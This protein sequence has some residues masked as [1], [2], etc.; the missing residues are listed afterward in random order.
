V[1]HAQAV[2][3][4]PVALEEIIVTA[5]RREESLQQTAIAVTA[6]SEDALEDV[7]AQ[8]LADL[9]RLAP[10]AQFGGGA[11]GNSLYIRGIGQQQ[12][13]ILSDPGSALYV[14]GVYRPHVVANSVNFGGV[15]RI[16]VLRGPQG[17]LFGKN[18]VGGSVNIITAT[19][20]DALNG[21]VGVEFGSRNRQRHSGSISMPLVQDQL[22]AT[23]AVERN[24][25]DG[26]VRNLQTGESQS[27]TDYTTA[28]ASLQWKLAEDLT[29]TL[30]G[31]ATKQDEVGPG[32][33]LIGSLPAAAFIVADPYASQGTAA[34]YNYAKDRG[35]SLTFDWANV[36]PGAFKSITAYRDFR[37]NFATDSDS[38]PLDLYA[39]SLED[40]DHFVS[41]ELQY[42]ASQLDD[43]LKWTVGLFYM[44][45]TS[46]DA[47]H[48]RLGAIGLLLDN[49]TDLQTRS[50]AAFG[51]ATYSFTDQLS[52]T[53]GLRYSRDKKEV[54]F[55]SYNLGLS[56][57]EIDEHQNKSWSA[58]TP[59][60]TL[61]YQPTADLMFYGT[62]S[63]GY[64]A[65]GYNGAPTNANGFLS[66]DPEYLWNY[67]A[68][69]KSE[70]LEH[71][72]RLN[73]TGY[74]MEYTDIQIL[75]NENSNIYVANTGDARVN[76]A[77]AELTLLAT[78][79]L[80]FNA[81]YG[82]N[83]FKYTR[84]VAGSNVKA[85][86]QISRSPKNSATGGFQYTLDLGGAGS[87]AMRSDY[88]WRSKIYFDAQNSE[89]VAQ[90]AYGLWS[91]RVTYQPSSKGWE[92]YA[93]GV[94]LAD[95]YYHAD[96]AD[97]APLSQYI[98][99]GAPRE[100]G[101]GFKVNFGIG[102]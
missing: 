4:A 100:V 60:L 11:G 66:F 99:P 90:D 63:K 42:N 39:N 34:T 5:Q 73:L 1:S 33:K 15:Q 40:R 23:L 57:V 82:L 79:A 24:T 93:Y 10:N 48:P 13:G 68:G 27:D 91:A 38:S 28:R 16:E 86:G 20:G 55:T 78:P 88:S 94:N 71:R 19:P 45:E 41:E 47:S 95:K 98:S 87:L 65:G 101:A 56:S 51:Q 25:Q 8:S 97:Q 30:R 83:D 22:G 7:H 92:V 81:S 46:F 18:A 3:E 32:V 54:D 31:D 76:G 43:R 26:S 17:T 50:V 52:A 61:Q 9:S 72:L 35:V 53:L 36:G 29:F 21:D 74:R 59:K 2:S 64:K 62:A 67:E 37:H 77:E 89:A 84:L 14:D 44:D 69:M 70:W 58:M 75:F 6:I 80:L 12:P 85:D 49:A 96:A 102:R